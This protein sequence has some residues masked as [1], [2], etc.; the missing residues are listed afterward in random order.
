M[1]RCLGRT[2]LGSGAQKTGAAG[3]RWKQPSCHSVLGQGR[4]SRGWRAGVVSPGPVPGSAVSAGGCLWGTARVWLLGGTA[5]TPWYGITMVWG[6]GLR[7]R[8]PDQL[9][10]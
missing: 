8:L 3:S 6:R 9:A 4:S 1:A 10:V 7:D 2:H 5:S